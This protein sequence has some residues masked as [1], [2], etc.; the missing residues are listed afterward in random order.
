MEALPRG[1]YFSGCLG[2]GPK[3]PGCSK[4]KSGK[5]GFAT[6]YCNTS[7]NSAGARAPIINATLPK[8]AWTLNV[9]AEEGSEEDVYRYNPWRAPGYAPVVDPCGMAG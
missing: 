3:S 9:G 8:E 7:Y 1:P 6:R 2:D 5:I 4:G